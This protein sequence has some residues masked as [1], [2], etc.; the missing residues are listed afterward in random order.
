MQNPEWLPFIDTNPEEG[1]ESRLRQLREAANSRDLVLAYHE[2]FPGLGHVKRV[3]AFF[4]WV[5]V[6]A[7]EL[8][9]RELRRLERV[10]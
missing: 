4:D 8:A 9:S 5:A 6:G 7:H 2:P 1:L 3:G 10:E